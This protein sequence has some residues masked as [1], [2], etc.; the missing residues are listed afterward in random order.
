MNL[1]Q[2]E[3]SSEVAA[4]TKPGLAWYQQPESI[5]PVQAEQSAPETAREA[6]TQ[7][8]AQHGL[9][10]PL[11]AE[12]ILARAGALQEVHQ[13]MFSREQIEAVAADIGIRPEFVQRAIEQEK[14]GSA[15]ALV[16]VNQVVMTAALPDH[17]HRTKFRVAATVGGCG[18]VAALYT[19]VFASRSVD[20]RG[21]VLCLIVLPLLIS[22]A[23]GALGKNRRWGAVSGLS[24]AVTAIAT[25]VIIALADGTIGSMDAL[26]WKIFSAAAV[27]STLFGVV[28]AQARRVVSKHQAS[29]RNRRT[30]KV[31]ARP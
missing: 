3:N 12:R 26:A 17:R 22:L 28:G 10:D 25:C 7:P 6:V 16:E 15:S 9:F 29:D 21:L 4:T 11:E 20:E 1:R 27:S 24:I 19:G 13:R 30:I 8:Q 5:G 23:L 18:L 31:S 14:N 2:H